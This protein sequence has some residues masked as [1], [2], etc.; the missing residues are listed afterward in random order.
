VVAPNEAGE[1]T[2]VEELHKVLCFV[3]PHRSSPCKLRWTL[4]LIKTVEESRVFLDQEATLSFS[5][6][7]SSKK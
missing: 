4:F 1:A 3:D 6:T 5:S 7:F 2:F